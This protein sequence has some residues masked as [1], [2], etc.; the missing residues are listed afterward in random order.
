[1]SG[2][3]EQLLDLPG[4]P[5]AVG[6]RQLGDHPHDVRRGHRRTADRL[7]VA[8]VVRRRARADRER[9]AAR[10]GDAVARR[11]EVGVGAGRPLLAARA[12]AGEGVV[13]GAGLRVVVAGDHQ[14]AGR[15]V[16]RRRVG[17]GRAPVAA[18]VA[19]SPDHAHALAHQHALRGDRCAVLGEGVVVVGSGDRT[20][21]VVGDPDRRTGRIELAALGG[22]RRTRLALVLDDPVHRGDGVDDVQAGAHG[23]ADEL[24]LRRRA[25]QTHS[26]WGGRGHL[27]PGRDAGHVRA[28]AT[29]AVG[30]GVVGRFLLEAGVG[31]SGH[32]RADVLQ[33]ADD[34][35]DAG[36][37]EERVRAVDAG[38]DHGDGHAP[39]VQPTAVGARQLRE[40][41]VAARRP[42][43]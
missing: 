10:R 14:D 19:G 23:Q 3:L 18:V 16:H 8:G 15:R 13:A 43:R 30:V 22:R 39:A 25:A 41:L 11:G 31:R 37:G 9:A 28:V 29:P 32:D 20:V 35:A 4:R 17:L 12:E 33:V 40:R 21:G 38:V 34:L 6:L 24:G 1:M 27:I 36:P 7:V 42:V 2:V 5:T 26:G